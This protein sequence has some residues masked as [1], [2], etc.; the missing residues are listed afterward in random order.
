M[1]CFPFNLIKTN[2][3]FMRERR[4]QKTPPAMILPLNFSSLSLQPQENKSRSQSPLAREELKAGK[5]YF[6]ERAKQLQD[7]HYHIISKE[8]EGGRGKNKSDDCKSYVN[9]NS[10]SL[11]HSTISHSLFPSHPLFSC[12]SFNISRVQKKKFSS[13]FGTILIKWEEDQ[14]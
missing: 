9:I 2:L 11:I 13:L 3:F 6:K 10:I 7:L 5:G 1:F 12:L 8:L 4:S 14:S